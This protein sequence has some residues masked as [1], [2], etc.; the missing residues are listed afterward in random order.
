MRKLMLGLVLMM[1]TSCA[2][3][4]GPKE[5]KIRVTDNGFEPE[6]VTVEKGKPVTLVFMREV[7]ATCATEAVF[8]A[9][10]KRYELPFQQP[11]RV[12]LTPTETGRLE[13]AC[14]MDMYK[15]AVEVK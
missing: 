9:D 5:V 12:E 4:S 11:V 8:K 13:Y 7:E 10:G 15:G 14:A 1:A 6:V 2:S 3:T